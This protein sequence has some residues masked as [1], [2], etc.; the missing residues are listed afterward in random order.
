MRTHVIQGALLLSALSLATACGNPAVDPDATFAANGTVTNELGQPLV[1]AEVRLIKYSSD[2]QL[3]APTVDELF[4]ESPRGD[5]EVGLDVSVVQTVR[6]T[7]DGKFTMSFKGQDIAAPGGYTT[8]EGLV[9][10]ATVVLVVRDPADP[11]KR[12]GVYTYPKLFMQSDKEWGAGTMKLWAAEAVADTTVVNTTGLVKLSWKKIPQGGSMVRNTYRVSVGA[13]DNTSPRLIIRCNEGNDTVE[14]ACAQDTA[15]STKVARWVSAYSLYRYYSSGGMFAAYVEAN[16]PDYRFVAKFIVPAPV[17]NNT[18][19]RTDVGIEGLWAVS[20]SADQPLLNTPATDGN[21]DTRVAITIPNATA[22]YAKLTPALV[23]DA[24]VLNTVLRN[25]NNGCVI[26]EFSV[27]AFPDLAG[28][29][30]SSDAMWV[31]KGKFCGENGAK[32]EISALAGFDTT[33]SDGV[34]AAWM[35]VRAE[36]DGAGAN[37][38]FQAI[39]EVAVLKKRQ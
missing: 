33:G 39:G 14:G 7:S 8:G 9:E 22:I 18:G 24:G 5:T 13:P 31:R 26:L 3:L 11:L 29:K 28:A 35:R 21:P 16:S 27:T 10:V 12:A 15:D 37:P 36:A 1:N 19:D 34:V 38:Y 4:S 30:G 25:A 6:T 32:D 23:S 2:L 17:P 20:T